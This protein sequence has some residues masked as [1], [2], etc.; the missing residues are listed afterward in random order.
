MSLKVQF[1]NAISAVLGGSFVLLTFHSPP[2]PVPTIINPDGAVIS[3]QLQFLIR[4]DPACRKTT[5]LLTYELVDC[6]TP[7]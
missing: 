1:C 3:T 4:T 6:R 2:E 7:V 5:D